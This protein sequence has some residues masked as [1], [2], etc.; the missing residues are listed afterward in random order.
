MAKKFTLGKNERLKSRKRLEELF[1]RGKSFNQSPIRVLYLPVAEGLQAGVGVSA[2][3]FK[4]AVDRNRI[5]RLIREAWRLQKNPLQE[6]LKKRESGLIVFLNYT[7]REKPEYPDVFE[8]IR[9]CISKL[10]NIPDEKSA[11]NT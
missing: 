7:F 4:K 8:A 11:A 2:R 9:K 1:N 10:C 5:K 6:I 3:H